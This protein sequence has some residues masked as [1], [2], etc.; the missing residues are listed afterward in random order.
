MD[1]KVYVDLR[2]TKDDAKTFSPQVV[3]RVGV[4]SLEKTMMYRLKILWNLKQ[5]LLF[6]LGGCLHGHQRF[7]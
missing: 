2:G 1:M 3:L 4:Q 5:L 7:I 6:T